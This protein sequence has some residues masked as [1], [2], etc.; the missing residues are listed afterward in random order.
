[1][2]INTKAKK[3]KSICIDFDGVI[4]DYSS[5]WQGIDVFDKV[6]PGASE[7]TH[8]LHDAGYMI[9]IHTTRNDTP[10]LRDFLNKNDICFDYINENPCQPKGSE[11][12]KVKA[13]VYL[14]DR[15]VCFTGDWNEALN[16]ILNFKTWQQDNWK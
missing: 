15:G 6:L 2:E 8:Q 5:G 3:P 12:G 16:Q 1:M 9:I 4:H 11:F 10:A 14:D 13:D 7:A